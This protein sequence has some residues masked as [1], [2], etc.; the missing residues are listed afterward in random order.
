MKQP[1]IKPR[2]MWA[3]ITEGGLLWGVEETKSDVLR[4]HQVFPDQGETIQRVLVTAPPK[5]RKK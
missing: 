2:I 5:R 3:A 4:R 1:K